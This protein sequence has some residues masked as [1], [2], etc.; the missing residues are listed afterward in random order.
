[1]LPGQLPGIPVS[2]TPVP[3]GKSSRSVNIRRKLKELIDKSSLY[4]TA[5]QALPT[6][7]S[8]DTRSLE[9]PSQSSYESLGTNNSLERF[10]G[11]RSVERSRNVIQESNT[12]RSNLERLL[13]KKAVVA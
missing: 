1:M 2:V 13:I 4:Q 5:T 3:N 11:A 9:S 7:V 10:Y 6:S 12:L 8:R